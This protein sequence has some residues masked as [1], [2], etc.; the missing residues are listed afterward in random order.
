MPDPSLVAPD[1]YA[2]DFAQVSRPG[3]HDIQLDLFLDYRNNVARYPEFQAYFRTHRP[4]L[5]AVWGQHDPFFLPQGAEAFKRD[6]PDAEVHF[7]DTG[8][9][10]LESH[11]FEIGLRIRHFLDRVVARE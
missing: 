10:A 1:A 11:G 3:N 2:L 7:Y 5:L 9:F 8:H 6:L 4:S